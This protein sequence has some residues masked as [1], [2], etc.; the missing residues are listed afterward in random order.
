MTA[1]AASEG[2]HPVV[3]SGY[4]SVSEQA[5]AFAD[6]ER[7]HGRGCGI[8]WVA[9]PGRSEHA[10]GWAVDLGDRETPAADD[11]IPFADTPAGL[12]LFRRAAEFGFEMSFPPGNR[13]NIGP[14]P[15]HFRCVGTPEARAT[16]HPG[17]WRTAIRA[18][19]A[20]AAYVR[21]RLG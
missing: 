7:R 20:A 1:A 15:W 16:F 11:E 8:R 9:P 6:A 19:S 17:P 4:R 5:E 14:E 21:F 3:L 2:V 18:V 12:W 10:T 13:Q